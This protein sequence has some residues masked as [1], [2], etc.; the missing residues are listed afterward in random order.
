MPSPRAEWVRARTAE[1]QYAA[2]LRKVA[3]HIADLIQGFD[4]VLDY[5]KIQ[6]ALYRYA[7]ILGPWAASVATRMT[8]EVAARNR[9]SWWNISQ[10]ISRNLHQ[11]I[12]T[13]PTGAAIQDLIRSQV[14]LITS[15]PK[16]AASRVQKLALQGFVSGERPASL[17]EE[18]MRTGKVVRSRAELIAQT[19]TSRA[20]TTITQV[21]A[22]HVGSTQYVWR[23]VHDNHVRPLHRELDGQVFAWASPP[24]ADARTGA[25][26]HPGCIYR[27]R[28]FA[29]PIIPGID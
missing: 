29:E 25:R 17:V 15:M 2:K 6:D 24:V 4:P 8:T 22:E 26:A 10:E 27:C 18:I 14:D 7:E 13:A 11:E 1:R 3:R 23:S 28:C 5:Q 19:E 9:K 20:M 12:D 21:R 16:D